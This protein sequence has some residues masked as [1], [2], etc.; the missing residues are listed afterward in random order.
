MTI[1]GMLVG[2]FVIGGLFIVDDSAYERT[3]FDSMMDKYYGNYKITD[4]LTHELMIVSYA[5]NKREP[6]FFTKYTA[7]S[8]PDTFDVTVA[9][10]AEASSA[11]PGYFKPK[12]LNG[13][14]L[15]DGAM[16]ANNPAYFASAFARHLYGKDNI[17]TISVGAGRPWV[18]P[19]VKGESVNALV[20]M[21]KL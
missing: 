9:E 13:E 17:K 8:D 6:R 11:F 16:I 4:A 15:V 12:E 3:K 5:Y 18:E 20:W 2:G 10:A 14:V 21:E 19:L 7:R 1:L